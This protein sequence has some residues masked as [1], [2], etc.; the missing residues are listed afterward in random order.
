MNRLLIML[1]LLCFMTCIGLYF[2]IYVNGKT[3]D[4]MDK[5]II[6]QNDNFTNNKQIIDSLFKEEYFKDLLRNG[7]LF[8]IEDELKKIKSIKDINIYLNNNSEFELS[9]VDRTAIAFLSDSNHFIDN[10]GVVF[11][12]KFNSN[13]L[14]TEIDGTLSDIEISRSIKLLLTFNEDN[15]FENKIKK[16]WFKNDDLYMQIKN[17]DFKIRLGDTKNIR[18]KLKMLKGFYAYQSKNLSK[19]KYKQVDLV[20][21]NQLVAI[22]K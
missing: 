20:Y 9:F 4:L 18:N 5:N 1:L 2:P 16:I 8:E 19:K 7:K 15:F 13:E 14:L 22:K 17:L 10:N 6:Y 11:M 3:Y 12:K 21:Q